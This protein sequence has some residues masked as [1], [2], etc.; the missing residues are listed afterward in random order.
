[1]IWFYDV[2]GSETR[3]RTLVDQVVMGQSGAPGSQQWNTWTYGFRA[4]DWFGVPVNTEYL[5]GVFRLGIRV[6]SGFINQAA[7]P[8][9]EVVADIR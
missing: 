6:V 4:L 1:M 3:S 7:V 8:L 9:L 2:T 5:L